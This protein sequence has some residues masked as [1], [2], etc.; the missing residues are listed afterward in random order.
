MCR[1]GEGHWSLFSPFVPLTV[2][3]AQSVFRYLVDAF[4][5]REV[6]RV[7]QT[8]NSSTTLSLSEIESEGAGVSENVT[9][10]RLGRVAPHSVWLRVNLIG[11]EHQSV[12]DVC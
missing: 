2:S 11:Y 9:A 4:A 6:G 12:V 5:I 3:V 1:H 7:N 10:D 8:S